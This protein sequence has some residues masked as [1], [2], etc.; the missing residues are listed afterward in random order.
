[1]PP[2]RTL[3]T[4][5]I[6]RRIAALDHKA[7]DDAVKRQIVVIAALGQQPEILDRLRR[8]H[9][10]ELELDRSLVSLEGRVQAS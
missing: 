9:R 4:G 1:V 5:A 7:L 3:A 10:Q 2:P 6:A 8:I